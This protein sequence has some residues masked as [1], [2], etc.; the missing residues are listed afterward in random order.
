MLVANNNNS[1]IIIFNQD[2]FKFL[3]PLLA[4]MKFSGIAVG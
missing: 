1:Y 3:F 4:K 2:N